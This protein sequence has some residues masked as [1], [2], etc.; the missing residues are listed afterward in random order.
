MKKN[1]KT[2]D[3]SKMSVQQIIAELQKTLASTTPPVELTKAVSVVTEK[4]QPKFNLT[5]A[6]K[7][8]KPVTELKAEPSFRL[9]RG[10]TSPL[11]SVSSLEDV[12][13]LFDKES[14]VLLK[15]QVVRV[16]AGDRRISLWSSYTTEKGKGSLVGLLYKS[17]YFP[18]Q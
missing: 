2:V 9:K 15:K 6:V 3:Y 4:P 10:T 1:T 12:L 17:G 8:E 13:N 18:Q 14:K 5:P 16:V 11:F 7:Q